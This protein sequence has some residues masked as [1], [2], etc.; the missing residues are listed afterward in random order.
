MNTRK[1]TRG[2]A[3]NAVAGKRRRSTSASVTSIAR[4]VPQ[5]LLGIVTVEHD[6]AKG[7]LPCAAPPDVIGALG[8]RAD[9]V[10]HRDESRKRLATRGDRN[11]PPRGEPSELASETGLRL[12]R[13]EILEQR[14]RACGMRRVPRNAE[15]AAAE[16]RGA[17]RG[18]PRQRRGADPV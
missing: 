15:V 10:A 14:A 11:V 1:R 5:R 7:A 17:A 2:A 18:P 3:S 13:Q 12:A 16:D 4:G 9:R 8:S 6:G